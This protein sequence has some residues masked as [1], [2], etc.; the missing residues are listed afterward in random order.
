MNEANTDRGEDIPPKTLLDSLLPQIGVTVRWACRYYHQFPDQGVI[1]DLRQE[2]VLSL[3]KDDFH[4]LRSFEHRSSGK[5]WLQMVVLHRVGRHFK[6]QKPAERLEDLPIDSLPSQPPSQEV[7]VLHKEREGLLGAVRSE[8][9][10]KEQ[11]LWDSLRSG[12]SDEEIAKLMRIKVSRYKTKS[13][14]CLRRLK[15]LWNTVEH[16]Q[17]QAPSRFDSSEVLK[18]SLADDG[19]FALRCLYIS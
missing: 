10:E 6:S 14:L 17:G 9:T 19:H 7:I 16:R 2:I 12:S 18:K 5:T 4:G 1:D 15:V 8:L 3:I 13:M 11:E